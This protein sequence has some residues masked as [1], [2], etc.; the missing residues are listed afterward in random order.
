MIAFI[1]FGVFGK[2]I[3]QL[4]QISQTEGSVIVFDDSMTGDG[5]LTARP[6][7][8][9]PDNLNSDCEVY[10]GLGYNHLPL[11][12]SALAAT[13]ACNAD[14][15][16]LV[17]DSAIMADSVEVGRAVYIYRGAVLDE[18]VSLGSG[19]VLNNRVTISHD[20]YVGK[21]SFLAPGVV[22]CGDVGIG[23]RTFIGAGSVV[24]NGVVIGD[25]VTI[26]AG[27]LVA[28]DVPSGMT[29]IGNPMKYL[30]HKLKM[31]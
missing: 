22:V 6:F 12:E 21:C 28:E 18:N 16:S 13:E 3:Y 14:A 29:V 23:S 24:T 8:S 4:A 11:R 7:A 9:F 1:G 26:G 10:I 30:T 25:D 17:H 15:P 5:R 20:S 19:T 2:Q 31:T 27:T